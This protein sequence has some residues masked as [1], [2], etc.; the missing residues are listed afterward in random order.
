MKD[1]E[2]AYTARGADKWRPR[3]TASTGESGGMGG[4]QGGFC[5]TCSRA[6]S[7]KLGGEERRGAPRLVQTN[8]FHVRG[9]RSRRGFTS[10]PVRARVSAFL[11]KAFT[12]NGFRRPQGR[13]SSDSSVA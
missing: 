12:K 11:R 8:G 3:P 9:Y 5:C 13:F 1:R 6:S 10:S 2:T 7:H 4:F